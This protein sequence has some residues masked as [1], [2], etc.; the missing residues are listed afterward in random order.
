MRIFTLTP[1]SIIG[2]TYSNNSG[3]EFTVIDKIS[4]QKGRACKYV[5][6]F[7]KSGYQYAVEKV[8]ITRGTVRDRT[9]RSVFGVGYLGDARM[10]DHKRE[11]N[12]WNGML[13][14]CYDETSPQFQDY[15]A[16]GVT[17]CERWHCFANF[18]KDF[19]FIDGFEP[20]LFADRKIFLDKDLKQKGIPKSEMV[21]S[22][23]TCTFVS[24]AVNNRNRDL[25]KAR[26]LF[27]AT[28]PSGESFTVS[29]L[30][31]FAAK[32]G[33]HRPTIKKCLRGERADYNGWT[34]E[35]IRESNWGRS[36]SA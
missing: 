23:N 24:Q 20:D 13:E 4:G 6:R 25:T 26:L 12:V 27:K 2:T 15:G 22:L 11:Y 33:L 19:T 32:H 30:R 5:V 3:H 10:V 17:V 7:T 1:S 29:G 9:E 16:K 31:P 28:S 18:V 36:K 35:L 21:Y 34:F 14:R 8:Q